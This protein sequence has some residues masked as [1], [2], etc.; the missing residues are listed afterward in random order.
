MFQLNHHVIVDKPVLG[1]LFYVAVLHMRD[2]IIQVLTLKH[3]D[4]ALDKRILFPT[5][6]RTG[7]FQFLWLC[8]K[9]TLKFQFT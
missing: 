1:Y 7:V 5:T 6:C 2:L 8:T 4:T 3:E 9:S